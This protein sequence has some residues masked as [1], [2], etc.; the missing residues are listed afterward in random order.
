MREGG[1]E[2]KRQNEGGRKK[3]HRTQGTG[4]SREKDQ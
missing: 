4:L 3:G 1:E 2:R